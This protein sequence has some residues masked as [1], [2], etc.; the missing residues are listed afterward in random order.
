MS[1]KTRSRIS[2][3]LRNGSMPAY[4]QSVAVSIEH[5]TPEDAEFYLD[6]NKKNYRKL[7]ERLVQRYATDMQSDMWKFD[8]TP[9]CF[10]AGE[11]LSDGQHRLTAIVKSKVPQW[12]LIVRNLPEGTE[13]SP[14]KDTGKKRTASDHMAFAGHVSTTTIAAAIRFLHKLRC[15][16]EKI[17]HSILSDS[18]IIALQQKFP[19]INDASRH[20][21]RPGSCGVWA[22]FSYLAS[23]EN[24]PLLQECLSIYSE[25]IVSSTHHPFS[26]LKKSI[27]LGSGNKLQRT[28]INGMIQFDMTMAAWQHVKKGNLEIQILRPSSIQMSAAMEKALREFH[29]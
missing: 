15:K 29:V 23:M 21:V 16:I 22:A 3:A 20:T 6:M 13:T 12:C 9:I 7:D 28:N 5:V 18:M 1:T 2:G 4:L 8:G 19:S 24:D 10:T 26:R 17:E 11:V 14:A 27:S 25:H